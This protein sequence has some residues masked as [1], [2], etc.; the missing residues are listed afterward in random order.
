[1]TAMQASQL[2]TFQKTVDDMRALMHC[3]ICLKPFY[4][5]FTLACGHTYCYSCL[6]SWCTGTHN[7]GK[8]K[9]CPDCRAAITTQPSPNFVVRD[10]VQKFLSRAELLPD[11]ETVQEHDKAREQ[12][13]KVVA[14]DRS[15]RGLFKGL[16]RLTTF[17]FAPHNR[18]AILDEEDGVDRCPVCTWELEEEGC[19]HCGFTMSDDETGY[20]IDIGS[21]DLDTSDDEDPD[22][23]DVDAFGDQTDIHLHLH[24]QPP[25]HRPLSLFDRHHAEGAG[26]PAGSV[27]PRYYSTDDNEEDEDDDGE[28]DSFIERDEDLPNE[29]DDDDASVGTVH[30]HR[31]PSP[32]FQIITPAPAQFYGLET[33]DE[34]SGDE[35]SMATGEEVAEVTANDDTSTSDESDDS[36]STSSESS[37]QEISPPQPRGRATLKRRIV[38]SEDEESSEAESEVTGFSDQEADNNAIRPPQIRSVRQR[39]LRQRARTSSNSPHTPPERSRM[40]VPQRIHADRTIGSPR[41]RTQATVHTGR[42]GGRV[43]TRVH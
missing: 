27:S 4:E 42:R 13:A 19:L 1:M 39:R 21:V 8:V 38:L 12:E 7:R 31:P 30:G 26:Y 35:G 16:F 15:G 17:G 36:S 33:E 32:T 6:T 43:S 2:E 24:P 22:L 10:M 9:N 11:D 23:S 40:A 25:R 28:M 3:Q 29:V 18:R 34:G 20:S 5:P 37:V 41:G 14:A